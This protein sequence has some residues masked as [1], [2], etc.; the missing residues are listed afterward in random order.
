[1]LLHARKQASKMEKTRKE[2]N[3]WIRE[4]D[5]DALWTKKWSIR[6]T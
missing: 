4:E 5:D 2:N 6:P 1:M 3:K